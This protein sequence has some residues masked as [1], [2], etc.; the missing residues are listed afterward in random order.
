MDKNLL[1]KM[2]NEVSI[3]P[4]K[5]DLAQPKNSN[6]SL[7]WASIAISLLRIIKG[8]MQSLTGFQE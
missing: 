5:Y 8:V 7:F 3:R 2:A 4:I 6:K 1:V